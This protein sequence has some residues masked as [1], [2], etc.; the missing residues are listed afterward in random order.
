MKKEEF[1][2]LVAEDDEMVRG[3]ILKILGDEG[4]PVVVANDGLTA[5]ELLR[6]ED[7]KMV[8][9]DLRMPGADGMEVLRTALQINPQIV[10][11]LVTAYGT[12]DVVLEAMK[13]GAYDYLVKPFVMAQLLITVRNAFKL[14]SLMEENRKLMIQLKETYRNLENAKTLVGSANETGT[15]ESVEQMKKL[16]ELNIIDAVEAETRK[17]DIESSK[18]NESIKRYSSLVDNLRTEK[19]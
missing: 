9:T 6:L 15:A 1:K 5:I 12:L 7:V 4:Y 14:S 10:V 3:V 18:N 13:E 16:Q 2:I 8:I 11:V 17:D 19:P